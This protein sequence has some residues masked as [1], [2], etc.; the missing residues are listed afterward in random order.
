MKST[1]LSLINTVSRIY[2]LSVL[3]LILAGCSSEPM[4]VQSSR[5]VTV[6]V[7]ESL[8]ERD[9]KSFSGIIRETD[10]VKLSFRVA[11]QVEMISLG[12][13]QFTRKG[14]LLARLD[15]RDYQ[16]HLDAVR[17]EHD[18]VIAEVK[19]LRQLYARGNITESEHEKARAGEL[20]INAKLRA[21]ENALADTRL[22][23]PF[24]GFVQAL[25]VSEK[26]L[27]DAGSLILSLVDVSD[28]VIETSIPPAFYLLRDRFE[29]FSFSTPHY[30]GKIFPLELIGITAKADSANLYRLR[31]RYRP[32]SD[33]LLAPGMS[34]RVTIQYH[35]DSPAPV[36]VPLTAI[37]ARDE[38]RFIW[39]YSQ[40]AVTRRQVHTGMVDH[41]GMV[42]VHAG[43]S[44]GEM[45]VRSGVHALIDGQAVRT[46]N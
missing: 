35:R 32:G 23:A 14:D 36:R 6:A 25:Y 40:G 8:D 27:V 12:E 2:L 29:G 37:V 9:S 3:A 20:Q 39:V 5:P 17:A 19:R 33:C 16:L 26:E 21:A 24:D 41:N 44:A 38:E 22:M 31:L 10:L 15:S 43:L 30:P 34:V 46:G 1:M 18:Q 11:G 42:E 7:V 45:I 13:G 28:L 4:D